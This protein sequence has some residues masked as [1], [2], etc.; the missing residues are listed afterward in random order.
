MCIETATGRRFFYQVFGE[1]FDYPEQ[2]V[3]YI[4]K[5]LAESFEA[6]ETDEEDLEISLFQQGETFLSAKDH[7]VVFNESNGE[8]L[9]FLID[10][11]SE[12]EGY[13]L[14]L[15]GCAKTNATTFNAHGCPVVII[16]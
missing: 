2:V 15:T 10:L 3:V 16:Q 13:F 6:L 5:N 7:V 1:D 4:P 11:N 8:V 12:G 9:H 14:I